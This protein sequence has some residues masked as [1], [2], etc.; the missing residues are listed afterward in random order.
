MLKECTQDQQQSVVTNPNARGNPAGANIEKVI[1]SWP[2]T[3]TYF[4]MYQSN[5]IDYLEEP[6][7]AALTPR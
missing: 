3:N 4:T 2:R 6:D 7:P 5:E 1:R